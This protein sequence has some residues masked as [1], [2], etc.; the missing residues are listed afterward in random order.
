MAA[1]H[2]LPNIP[3]YQLLRTLGQGGMG[4]VF[5]A[6]RLADDRRLALKM[7]VGARPEH[8]LRFRREARVLAQLRHPNFVQIYDTG[9]CQGLPYFTMEL[10]EGGSLSDRR[11]TFPLGVRPAAALVELLAR[12]ISYAHGRGIV[13]R[14]L[15]P[16]NVLFGPGGQPKIAD[17]G[18]AKYLDEDAQ[19]TSSGHVMGTPAYMAPELA[20][21][22]TKEAGPAVDIY[23]LG[24]ILYEL[25]T[26]QSPFRGPVVEVLDQVRFEPPRRPTFLRPD[27]P[28]DLENICLKCLAKKP[29]QRYRTAGELADEPHVA[30][31]AVCP[32]PHVR[33][34]LPRTS[35]A[36]TG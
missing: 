27:V 11:S 22:K 13:H 6:T 33:H 3:G 29:W 34:T 5:E 2:P 36:V 32:M 8:V 20:W 4:V 7:I 35:K 23:A 26:G 21:G 30:R 25:L 12:A 1:E 28:A 16:A 17:F 24:A 31:R 10:V 14:D 19:L 15:K 9:E 18:L